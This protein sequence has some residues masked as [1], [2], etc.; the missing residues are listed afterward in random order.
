MEIKAE[1]KYTKGHEWVRV[2]G[3]AVAV[4]ITDYAQARLGEVV[5]VDLPEVGFAVSAGVSLMVVE[6]VK[7]VSDVYAPVSGIIARVNETLVDQPELLNE[8][9]YGRGWLA[10]LQLTAA[11]EIDQLLDSAAYGALVAGEGD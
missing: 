11:S 6:S 10:V 2:E 8:D 5:F 7:A 9:P 3:A 4:G 1:L